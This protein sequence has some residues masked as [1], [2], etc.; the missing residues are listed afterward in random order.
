VFGLGAGGG[1]LLQRLVEAGKGGLPV[2]PRPVPDGRGGTATPAP[3]ATVAQL[4]A[5]LRQQAA[6]LAA[7]FDE[8]NRT[9]A[10]GQELRLTL[11]SGPLPDLPI[12]ALRRPGWPVPAD[13]VTGTFALPGTE[14]KAPQADPAAMAAAGDVTGMAAAFDTAARTESDDDRLAVLAAWRLV[15]GMHAP[16]AGDPATELAAARLDGWLAVERMLSD[17]G[18]DEELRVAANEAGRRLR[19][20]GADTEAALHDQV[21]RLA[22][23]RPG[24]TSAAEAA[25]V[26]ADVT[27]LT[28]WTLRGGDPAQAGVAL[29]RLVAARQLAAPERSPDRPAAHGGDA[30]PDEAF[31]ISDPVAAGIA[32]LSSVPRD[33]LDH[34]QLRALARLLR[35]RAGSEPTDLAIATLNEAVAVLPT[36][37]RPRE[38][39]MARTDLAG[40]LQ[41]IDAEAAVDVY[42]DALDD[43]A[44]AGDDALRGSLLG[45]LASL[46]HMIGDVD[47]AADDLVRAIP[48]LDRNGDP[49]LAAQARCDLARALLDADRVAEAAEA[50]ENA[51]DLVSRVLGGAGLTPAGPGDPLPE[52]PELHPD[53]H[54]AGTSAFTAAEAA[55]ALG[56]TQHARDL[57]ELSAGWHRRNGNVVAEAE[58]WQLLAR[59]GGEPAENAAALQRAAE[60]ADAGGDWAR[61]ATCRTSRDTPSRSWP[62]HARPQALPTPERRIAARTRACSNGARFLPVI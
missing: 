11:E 43:A 38:R 51:L 62:A 30:T 34:Q 6:Q 4:Q 19:A 50:A 27:A 32:L 3:P 40:T 17:D 31:A 28:L 60:L 21:V 58:A 5:R 22:S 54:L 57:A 23:A 9:P 14:P 37:V 12:E 47:G 15:R 42:R 26:E 13:V 44:R 48:L 18:D 56:E 24:E 1:G 52:R 39:A 2:T 25:A 8:R 45:Q 49:L 55:A 20:A 29:S 35:V 59:C 46:R 61:A 36:G 41:S 7:R 53:V 10:V 16:S 33:D